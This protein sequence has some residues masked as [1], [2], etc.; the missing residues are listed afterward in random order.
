MRIYDFPD[1]T[2]SK[3]LFHV[4]GQSQEGGF[5][6]GG[7]RI[8][9]PEPGGRSILELT[10]ALQVGEWQNPVTSWLMSKINGQV[11]RVKLARTPQVVTSLNIAIPE[12]DTGYPFEDFYSRPRIQTDLEGRYTTA[13][14]E[15]TTSVVI[16]MRIFG[17]ILLPG[18]VIGHGDNCYLVDEISYDSNLQAT[19]VVTPPLRRDVTAG[20]TALFRP[21]FLGTISNGDSFRVTYDAEDIGMIQPGDIT[22]NEAVS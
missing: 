6:S 10:M 13:A 18:H 1:V 17:R 8:T 4:P 3:Q 5:T 21:N 20:D 9:S 19:V 15:G 14:L 2:I 12:N 11:L 16:D 22:F 7:A